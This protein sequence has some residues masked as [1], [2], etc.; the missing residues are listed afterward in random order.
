MISHKYRCIFIHIPR[1]AGTSIETWLCN[2]DW[3]NVEP[4]SKHLIASQAKRLYANWWDQYFKFAVVRHPLDRMRSCLHYSDHFGL[5]QTPNGLSFE[6]YHALFGHDIVLE[7]DHRFWNREDI[8]RN[9]HKP[10]AVYSNILDE[11]LDFI[12]RFEQLSEAMKFV[13]TKL[14][15][16][17]PFGQWIEKSKDVHSLNVR[18]IEAITQIYRNDFP[19]FGYSIDAV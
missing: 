12:A 19:R 1:C 4:H 10:G 18:D 7:H 8:L 16:P 14:S 2:E 5:Q 6:R 13:E 17:R 3:W 11:P 15:V 9:Q